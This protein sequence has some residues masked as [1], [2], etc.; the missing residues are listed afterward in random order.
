[1]TESISDQVL[2][3]HRG[4]Q[5]ALQRLVAEYLP[6]IQQ[7][8]RRKL[9]EALRRHGDTQDFVQEAVFDVLRNGPRFVVADEAGF[10]ALLLR[11]V[12]NNLRDRYR[13]LFRG[14]RDL[15]RQR[16]IP[17]DSVLML[18]GQARSITEPPAHAERSERTAWMGL[19]LEML[20][21]AD[22][23]VIRLRVWDGNTFAEIGK[24]MDIGEEAARKRYDRALPRLARKLGM[25]RQ[26][27][28]RQSLDA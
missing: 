28:W 9:T 23:E 19:A 13:H 25:L 5:A 6:W 17:S 10:R 21:P 11:I 2:L 24:V 18:D 22:R 14:R 20:E 3:V 7:H 1:M 4:D 12:E 15:R 16:A 27:N 26:G 8:V